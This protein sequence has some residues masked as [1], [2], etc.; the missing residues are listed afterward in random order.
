[1]EYA[2]EHENRAAGLQF[3]VTEKMTH[4]WRQSTD[5]LQAMESGKKAD[6]GK[7]AQWL[8]L[9]ESLHTWVLEQRAQGRALTVQ[10]CLKAHTLAKEMGA[11]GF[12]GGAS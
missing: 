3:D 11:V 5:K 1:M 7:K 2:K 10:L 12:V 6:Q 4:M 9:E 8:G